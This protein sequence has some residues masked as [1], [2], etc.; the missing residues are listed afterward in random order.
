[1]LDIN[2]SH[3]PA[4]T[5]LAYVLAEHCGKPEE[6]LHIAEKAKELAP[7]SAAV[8]DVFGWVLY[9]R[10]LHSLAAIHLA[11]AAAQGCVRAS[12]HLAVILSR[13]GDN[14]GARKAFD[15][16]L[17]GNPNLPEA[18]GARSILEKPNEASSKRDPAM[19]DLMALSWADLGLFDNP[20]GRLDLYQRATGCDS[21]VAAL[22]VLLTERDD[23][24][25]ADRVILPLIMCETQADSPA[26]YIAAL[27]GYAFPLPH[28]SG[29]EN[30]KAQWTD[31]DFSLQSFF[32]LSGIQTADLPSWDNTFVSWDVDRKGLLP[33]WGPPS[34][35]VDQFTLRGSRG[36]EDP[37]GWNIYNSLW[38]E[39]AR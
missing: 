28:V 32:G 12:Y 3:V 37:V 4:L 11:D 29:I 7:E 17:R 36:A 15:A 9:R 16:G 38:P 25:F 26:A 23:R 10:G 18:A 27:Q 19:P 33:N 5:N 39:S 1:V 31:P 2:S 20:A 21:V 14:A 30:A 24:Q 35:D 6:A 8:D 22:P 34:I 13:S